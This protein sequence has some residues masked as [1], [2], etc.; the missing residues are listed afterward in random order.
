MQETDIQ[1][2]IRRLATVFFAV[3]LILTIFSN[4]ILNYMLPEVSSAVVKNDKVTDKISGS[5]VVMSGQEEI[6][7]ASGDRVIQK[8]KVKE[9]DNVTAGQSL[10]YFEEDASSESI[11]QSEKVVLKDLQLQYDKLALAAAPGYENENLQIKYAR[12]DLQAA[13]QAVR[14]AKESEA[15]KDGETKEQRI[16]EAKDNQQEKERVLEQLLTQLKAQKKLDGRE[17]QANQI[18]K[19]ALQEQ[20]KQQKEKF[21]KLLKEDDSVECRAKTNGVVVTINCA[22][23]EKITSDTTLAVIQPE[24][25]ESVLSFS[26]SKE[27]SARIAVGDAAVSTDMWN[28]EA[29][30]EVLRIEADLESPDTMDLVTL[31][32]FG[33]VKLNENRIF[34]VGG[35]T[36]SY[37]TVVPNSA[38]R[39]DSQG[40]FVY[41][42]LAKSSPF[43]N[44]YYVRRVGITVEASDDGNSAVVGE[45]GQGECVITNC[46][47]VLENGDSVRLKEE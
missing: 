47:V 32:V 23:G 40:D 2:K 15:V 11:L 43:G 25:K 16:K 22:V 35:R 17:Q 30:G 42:L 26:V 5:G 37:E 19:N 20:I 4:T 39:E 34:T 24:E 3:L 29:R 1:K 33:N 45:L 44:R 12:E 36:E 31:Q 28:G 6:V 9:G 21:N 7:R 10:F 8:I 41:K 18:E 14:E 46:S 13:K 38:I 27:E